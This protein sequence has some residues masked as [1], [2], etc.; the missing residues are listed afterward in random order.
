MIRALVSR[1]DFPTPRREVASCCGRR[2]SQRHYAAGPFSSSAKRRREPTSRSA[3]A[4][5]FGPALRFHAVNLA[6]LGRL[7]ESQETVARLLELE[8]NL[9]LSVLRGRAPIA[10]PRLMDLFLN[11]LRKAGPLDC[12]S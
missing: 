9:T 12:R 1:G 3:T 5:S 2:R 6:E 4:A 10:D 8:P 11:D 7:D